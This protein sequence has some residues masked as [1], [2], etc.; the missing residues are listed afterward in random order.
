MV[1]CGE[2]GLALEEEV[3]EHEVVGVLRVL[4]GI[5]GVGVHFRRGRRLLRGGVGGGGGAMPGVVALLRPLVFA[6]ASHR[7][8]GFRRAGVGGSGAGAVNREGEKEEEGDR[9]PHA[10]KDLGSLG[11]GC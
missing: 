8:G 3:G 5:W 10:R 11:L 1:G 9:G 2:G 4:V 7:G 6:G